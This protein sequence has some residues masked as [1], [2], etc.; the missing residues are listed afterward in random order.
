VTIRVIVAVLLDLAA[1]KQQNTVTN[2]TSLGELTTERGYKDR[3]S[4]V[5]SRLGS[6]Q[7]GH[8]KGLSLQIQDNNK[9][10]ESTM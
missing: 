10:K 7:K 5:V 4:F 8:E 6:Y 3:D 1:Q 9:Q 2:E